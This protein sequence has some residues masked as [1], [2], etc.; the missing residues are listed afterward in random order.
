MLKKVFNPKTIALIGASEEPNTVGS[1]IASNLLK[2][3]TKTYF[4]NP[5]RDKVF[6]K[7]AYSSILDIK[8]N[9]DLVVIAVN[10]KI[11]TLIAKQCVEK[12]VKGVVVISDGFSEVGNYELERE[13][14][15]ILRKA[16]IPLIGP[17]CLGVINAKNSINASFAPFMPNKGGVAL[18]SQSG[19]LIDSIIDIDAC[20][21]SKIISFG[22]EADLGLS[23][24]LNYLKDDKDT[25][26]IGIYIEG[27]KN[28][29]EFIKTAKKITKQ[30]PI[31]IL[32]A[33]KGEAGKKA[34]M[35][36]T[37][38]LAGDSKIYSTVFKQTGC[39]EVDTLEEFLDTLKIL[40]LKKRTKNGL[41]I[42]T[43]GGG[44]GVLASDEAEKC[45]ILLP[46]LEEKTLK[47]LNNCKSLKVVKNKKNPLDLIGDASPK[48][49]EDAINCLV[50]QK[51]IHTL[52]IM[53]GKQIMTEQNKNAK[54]IVRLQK[55]YK[56]KIFVCSFVGGKS[57]DK[58]RE[59]IESAGIPEYSYPKRAILS[60]K[61]IIHE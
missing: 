43:N 38:S 8:E 15:S 60:I 47:E 18:L 54:I 50:K 9:I 55:K 44:F 59:I 5:N 2:S 26:V 10:S 6:N 37:G 35:T 53:Q 39:I 30:K 12:K 22:N 56:D 14:V 19:A 23:D 28:G 33:G 36:H 29:K 49:Y 32:K 13:L 24:Y 3:K 34:A 61:N 48:R 40:N 27:I 16:K 20:G 41:G 11:V 42:I 51:N 31:V 45:K 1:G 58:A 52:L 4:V 57:F 21:F 17:N 7:K 46:E 25:K